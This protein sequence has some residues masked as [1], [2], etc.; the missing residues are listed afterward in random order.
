[1]RQDADVALAGSIPQADVRGLLLQNL[2]RANGEG[3]QWRIN[4]D[5]IAA[6]HDHLIA[7]PEIPEGQKFKGP[8][9]FIRG[10]T[11]DYVAD[12]YEPKIQSLFPNARIETVEG[13]GHWLHAEKPGDFFEKSQAFLDV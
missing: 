11:S 10:S 7:F 2:E 6:G 9:L 3:F 5:A 8:T 1:R 4:L 13:A 12:Q